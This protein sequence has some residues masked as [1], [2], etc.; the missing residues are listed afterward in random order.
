MGRRFSFELFYPAA[1]TA[2]GL[3]A[4]YRCYPTLARKRTGQPI[5]SR[6]AD[7]ANVVRALAPDAPIFFRTS[8]LFPA[9][10]HVRAFC[11]EWTDRTEWDEE[12]NEYLPVGEIAVAIRTGTEYALF[13]YAAVTSSMS[14]LFERSRAVW[15]RFDEI[16]RTAGGLV[17]LFDGAV[18]RGRLAYP[19]LP[20]GRASV[21]FDFFD[22]VLEE[23]DTYWHIDVDRYASAVL[24]QLGK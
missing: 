14:D 9:D 13:T 1:R 8:I 11:S 23:R 20:D 21:T 2:D 18:E 17:G 3:Q 19:I 10:E 7:P 22:Y 15:R 4:L 5:K 16:L 24:Q 6:G 12:G